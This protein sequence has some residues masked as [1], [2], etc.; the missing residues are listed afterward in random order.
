MYPFSNML[1]MKK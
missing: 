1:H